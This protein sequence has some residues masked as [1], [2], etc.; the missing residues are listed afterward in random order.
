MEP[1]SRLILYGNSMFLAGIKAELEQRTSFELITVEAKYP[2][3][4][5]LI[6]TCNP[7]VVLFDLAAEQPSFAF[8]LLRER[9]GLLL[10]GVDP[11]SD[12]L[13]LLSSQPVKASGMSDLVKVIK[14]ELSIA[15]GANDAHTPEP[16]ATDCP[17]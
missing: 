12:Q 6:D 3:A 16:L 8:S 13:L 1:S 5:A 9:P 11:C 17:E 7:R 14:K 2:D 10:I 15:A 4:A